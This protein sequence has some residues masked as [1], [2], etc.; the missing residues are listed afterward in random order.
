MAELSE[1]YSVAGVFNGSVA[2][3]Y[4]TQADLD[5]NLQDFKN[6]SD[7]IGPYDIYGDHFSALVRENLTDTTA[8]IPNG[9]I[10]SGYA[11]ETH[12]APQLF[13]SE[14][15][16]LIY[17]GACGSTCAVFS[18]LMKSQGGVRSVAVGGRPKP[19]PMQ[20]VAGSKGAQVF[21]YGYVQGEMLT[22]VELYNATDAPLVPTLEAFFETFANDPPLGP[23]L[24][25]PENAGR[26]NLRNNFNSSDPS[27][28][29]LEFIYEAAN[30]RLYYQ[31]QDL[32]DI[33]G[34]WDRVADVTWSGKKCVRGST[35]SADDT[36]PSYSWQTLPF[37]PG[38]AANFTLDARLPGN[39]VN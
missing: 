13:A 8:Q 14:D 22:I 3:V 16:V 4:Q 28:V 7:L 21:T 37:G 2:S 32:F 30:C 39:L 35:V 6:Y 18:E 12:I 33:T 15:I 23:S 34:L 26:F 25:G 1:L 27:E 31:P 11:N 17:D 10:V 36:M 29:P 9:L 5:V 20:G 38:A 19:G 24:S